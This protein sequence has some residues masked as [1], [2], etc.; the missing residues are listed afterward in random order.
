MWKRQSENNSNWVNLKGLSSTD[1][2]RLTKE[3]VLAAIDEM[4]EL[5]REVN[6]KQHILQRKPLV[7]TNILEE[8]IDTFKY[9]LSIALIYD[10]SPEE[11][12]QKFFD[13]SDIVDKRWHEERVEWGDKLLAVDIDG[14]LADYVTGYF[15]FLFHNDY[16]A[17]HFLIDTATYNLSERFGMNKA[18]EEKAKREFQEGGGFVSLP[19]F[20]DA[21]ETLN[22]ARELG[23]K[24]ALVSA[25]PY[26]EIRRIHSDTINWLDKNKIPYDAI[27]WGKDKADIVF[28]NLY[29]I[30]P[31]WFVEDR[32]KHAIELANEGIPVLLM[33]RPYNQ[34]VHH[35]KII[36]VSG[37]RDIAEIIREG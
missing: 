32:D 23:Y 10:F 4:V 19:V 12:V 29:P 24:I 34:G 21:L 30:E 33:D 5:L 31:T 11:F 15:D 28:A 26:L 36:R 6:Y 37:W 35:E 18:D 17:E 25:R 22:W 27:F 1:Q 14:V 2:E 3:Y 7:R 8:L 9:L 16:I 20:P 13:K